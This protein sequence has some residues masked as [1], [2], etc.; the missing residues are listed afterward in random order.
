MKFFT[1]FDEPMTFYFPV[2]ISLQERNVQD[3]MH[4]RKI[5]SEMKCHSVRGLFVVVRML[6]EC[7]TNVVRM[8]YECCTR[9][10]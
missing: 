2:H 9:M 4:Y 5:T 6:Y 1:N 8:L 3:S 7:C 10:S